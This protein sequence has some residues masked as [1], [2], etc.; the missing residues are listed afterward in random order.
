MSLKEKLN[1]A[2]KEAMKAKEQIRTSVLRMILS[3]LKYAQAA[4]N[5]H[6]DLADSEVERVVSTYHKRLV[7][8]LEDYPEGER[9]EAIQRE[10]GIVEEYLPKKAG[11]EAVKAAIESAM[12]STLERNF[13][14]LMKDVMARLGTGADGKLVSTMLKAKLADK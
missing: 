10:I 2:L 12:S 1:L 6:Q 4:V 14:L 3:E 7:K 8:S 5:I 13:G 11:P 9:R